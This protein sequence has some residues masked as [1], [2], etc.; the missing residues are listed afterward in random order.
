MFVG[1][2]VFDGNGVGISDGVLDGNGVGA[3]VGS[4]V[5]L[6][7]GVGVGEYVGA[8]GVGPALCF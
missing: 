5:I 7:G 6:A 8:V 4:D 2:G 3:D 1:N